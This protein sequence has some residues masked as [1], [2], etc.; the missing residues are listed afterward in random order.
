MVSLD[1][2]R[3]AG[4]VRPCMDISSLRGV[5][6]AAAPGVPG[7]RVAIMVPGMLWNAVGG[8]DA[9]PAPAAGVAMPVAMAATGAGGDTQSR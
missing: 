4:G 7:T 5:G 1:I 3:F 6:A 9:G 8:A 2:A